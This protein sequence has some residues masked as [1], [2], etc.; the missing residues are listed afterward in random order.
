MEARLG[1][2]AR[3]ML[4][5]VVPSLREVS[6]Q[7]AAGSW[8]SDFC[9][10]V[11]L[12]HLSYI[13]EFTDQRIPRVV[14]EF[15]PGPSMGVGLA[16][17]IAGAERYYALDV[18][19]H[20]N[21]DHNLRVFDDLVE[22]FKARP[23][24]PKDG[25]HIDTFPHPKDWNLPERLA[26]QFER[27][28]AESRLRAIRKDIAENSGEFIKVL[29]PWDELAVDL[30]D[31]IDWI[32]SHSALE[33]VDRLEHAYLCCGKWLKK[34]GI[35]THEIDYTS[36]LLTKRWNGQFCLTDIMWKLVRGRRTY[37]INRTAHSTNVELLKLNGMSLLT[38]VRFEEPGGASKSE[39]ARNFSHLTERD[40]RTTLA[41]LVCKPTNQSL[42]PYATEEIILRGLDSL[43]VA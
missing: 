19:E 8:S 43:R 12:R 30:S 14:A 15:G 35:M 21:R 26:A 5:F 23:S 29:I 25:I 42:A 33:H 28:M 2:L 17:L 38:E 24:I 1:P 41:F 39:F 32:I 4:S 22:L 7:Q 3:G 9:Y 13:L 31:S 40:A 16:A 36:H 34:D 11:F 37:A 6:E 10:S 18:V 20:A 27:A